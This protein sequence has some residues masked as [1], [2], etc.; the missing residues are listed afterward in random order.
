[1]PTSDPL[2]FFKIPGLAEAVTPL[3]S[4]Y[5]GYTIVPLH[6][7]EIFL[8]AVFYQA[9][10]IVSSIVSPMFCQGYRTLPKRTQLN[11]D[12]HVVSQV[13]A[14]LIL[15]L[16]FPLFTDSVLKADRVYG[17]TPYGGFV[18]AMAMGYFIWDIYICLRFLSMFGIGFAVHGIAAGFVF[19]QSMRPMLI[20][21]SPHFLLFE[22]STPFLNVNW[23]ASH[24]PE[25]TIPFSVQKINGLFLLSSFFFIRIVWGFYQASNVVMDLFFGAS[26]YERVHPL[27]SSIGVCVAN[28]SLDI[29]NVYWFYK[30]VR[31]A[32]RALASG[33]GSAAKKTKKTS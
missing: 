19:L 28:V 4:D 17:Y 30:M 27:W 12:I 14:I 11:F 2:A 29:L 15:A 10:Y 9:I 21:Y 3:M 33:S 16:S 24:L 8:S 7:E 18:S 13:Q 26:V 25:G 1:M 6:I 22:L 31:L 5:L 20:H 23:F 32:K